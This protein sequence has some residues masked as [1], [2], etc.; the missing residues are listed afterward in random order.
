[1]SA[2]DEHDDDAFDWRDAGPEEGVPTADC[3]SCPVGFLRDLSREA[4]PEV[5]LHLLA[6]ARELLLAMETVVRAA[7]S[8]VQRN[9]DRSDPGAAGSAPATAA[10]VRR[11]DIA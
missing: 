8:T 1:M 11:I 7:E 2:Y 5:T 6:A 10:R 3:T 4:Q 9:A